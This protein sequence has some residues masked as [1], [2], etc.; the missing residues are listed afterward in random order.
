[1]TPLDI[2]MK[3][4]RLARITTAPGRKYHQPTNTNSL[5]IEDVQTLNSLIDSWKLEELLVWAENR[6]TFPLTPNK[7]S[8]TIG[9]QADNPDWVTAGGPPVDL[10]RAGLILPNTQSIE[11]PLWVTTP[12]EYSGIMN[13]SELASE[14]LA[15]Y[16]RPE[17][18]LGVITPWP[19]P[20]TVNTVAL[21][22]PESVQQFADPNA[23][24]R[25]MPGYQ[26]ALEYNLALE[27]AVL[28]PKSQLQ[29]YV[30][31]E[32]K[33][34]KAVIKAK[35]AAAN[36]TT[37]IND[38]GYTRFRYGRHNRFDVRLGSYR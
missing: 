18:D 12:E 17:A 27:L 21:Y 20:T 28:Y 7:P 38:V 13:N 29:P 1:M 33:R 23:A 19:I 5:A 3:A 2:A 32:A 8:Y 36:R 9:D 37:L 14:P 6:A 30:V 24:I 16:Y 25:L 15:L 31:E 10:L 35:N 22:F 26:H 34:A 11:V 4:R